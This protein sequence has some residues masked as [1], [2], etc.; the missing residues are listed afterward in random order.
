[1]RASGH[2]VYTRL[3]LD[4]EAL[5]FFLTFPTTQEQEQL[6]AVWDASTQHFWITKHIYVLIKSLRV[7]LLN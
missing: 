4:N 1:M 2:H 3:S 5:F 6:E 7:K